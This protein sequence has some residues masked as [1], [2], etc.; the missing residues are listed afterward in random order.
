MNKDEVA[1][2]PASGPGFVG[3]LF[4]VL[5]LAAWG[6]AARTA[7][8]PV[9]YGG[10]DYGVVLTVAGAI[11]GLIL[12]WTT[13]YLFKTKRRF[14]SLHEYSVVGVYFTIVLFLV[15]ASAV[16]IILIVLSFAGQVN[17]F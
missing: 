6:M 9:T 12:L 3:W 4:G 8:V 14:L 16:A 17:D 1:A 2:K 10:V 11:I 15:Q 13:A 5:G 7:T